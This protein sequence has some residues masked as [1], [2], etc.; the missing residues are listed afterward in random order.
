[1]RKTDANSFGALGGG[2]VEG[3]SCRIANK[4]DEV[5]ATWSVLLLFFYSFPLIFK[6]EVVTV[7]PGS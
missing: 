1:M 6:T 2:A 3:R 7:A 5:L 4:M